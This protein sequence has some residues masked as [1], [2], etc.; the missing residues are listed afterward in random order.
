M[1]D[2][3]KGYR[4]LARQHL[5]TWG[6]RV[7]SDV[8]VVNTTGSVFEG[9]ILPRSET[10][11]DLHIVLKLKTGY[12]VGVHVDR[13]KEIT[14]VGFKEAVYKIP[15]KEFPRQPDLP[16]VTLL[17]TGGTIASRLD[18]RTGAVIPAFTPGELYGARAGARRHLQPHHPQDLRGVLREHGLAPVRGAGAGGRGRDRGRGRRRRHR[19][20]HRHH[21]PTPPPSC[22]SWSSR[23]RCRSSWSARSGP[24]TG[25]R[26]TRP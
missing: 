2:D 18:Y 11:D 3:L 26:A 24:P 12:N 5:E 9:V 4:G 6:V 7:W 16:K 21:G 20:R 25:R 8:K 23:A 17:G 19:P 15:E 1:S 10:N 22:R 14:E 13:V